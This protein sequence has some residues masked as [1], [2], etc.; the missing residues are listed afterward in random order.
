MK[1]KKNLKKFKQI[2]ENVKMKYVVI[3]SLNTNPI[4]VRH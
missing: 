3:I 2:F 4:D 1:A